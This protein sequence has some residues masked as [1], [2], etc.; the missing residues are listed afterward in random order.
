V[1]EEATLDFT[2]AASPSG[3]INIA[4]FQQFV[5]GFIIAI[6]NSE[7]RFAN[8]LCHKELAKNDQKTAFS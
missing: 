1:A 2:V 5:N 6:S 7:F 3:I 4:Y 8:S